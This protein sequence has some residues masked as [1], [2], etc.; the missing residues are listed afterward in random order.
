MEAGAGN[1]NT[2]EKARK[3]LPKAQILSQG[4]ICKKMRGQISWSRGI[5][6]ITHLAQGNDRMDLKNFWSPKSLILPDNA[7]QVSEPGPKN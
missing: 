2:L 1:R 3:I 6:K 7:G 4:K 5:K